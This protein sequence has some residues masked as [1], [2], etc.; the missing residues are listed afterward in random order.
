M[1]KKLTLKCELK[2]PL[3]NRI[4]IEDETCYISEEALKKAFSYLKKNYN[5]SAVWLEYDGY[6]KGYIIEDPESDTVKVITQIKSSQ[7]WETISF[8]KAK[9]QVYEEIKKDH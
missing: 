9:K 7:T 3:N 2:T 1:I 5:D 4:F 6:S 8:T